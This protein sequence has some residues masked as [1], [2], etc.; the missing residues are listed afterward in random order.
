MCFNE[1]S[2]PEDFPANLTDF[3][4]SIQVKFKASDPNL[5]YRLEWK[6]HP[7]LWTAARSKSATP[8]QVLEASDLEP[9]T[10]YELRLQ[11]KDAQGHD[12]YPSARTVVVDTE[13][14]GCTPGQKK[15]GCVIL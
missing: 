14:I 7:E 9:G 15:R 8:D 11:V 5:T 3:Q 4:T 6:K 13:A 2:R 10:T 12:G 1:S